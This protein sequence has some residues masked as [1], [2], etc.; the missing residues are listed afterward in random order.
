[1][2]ALEPVEGNAGRD[3]LLPGLAQKFSLK[4]KG[5]RLGPWFD[6]S[7]FEGPGFVRDDFIFIQHR[8][9]AKTVTD[10]AG[11][12]GV[13]EGKQVGFRLFISQTAGAAL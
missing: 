12:L 4:G 7:F 8:Q 1:M 13:V 3:A 11:S 9:V 2:L 10:R 6:R 5:G